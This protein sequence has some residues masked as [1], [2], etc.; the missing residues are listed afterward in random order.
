MCGDIITRLSLR[1]LA[2]LLRAGNLPAE[3]RESC[4][5]QGGRYIRVTDVGD[6]KLERI[7]SNEYLARADMETVEQL[8]SAALR[9]SDILTSQ[10]IK[11]GFELYD[12]QEKLVYYLHYQ[13]P[14]DT[15]L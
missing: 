10:R 8:L 15:V 3:V 5:Y 7:S 4:H 1:R 13:W 6:F 11:H 2:K 14:R 9:T 12:E